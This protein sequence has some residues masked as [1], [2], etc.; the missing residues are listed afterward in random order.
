MVKKIPLKRLGNADEL[1]GVLLLLCSSAGSFIT[2][3]VMRV[4]GGHVIA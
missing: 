4:D 3:S 2:G 1:D